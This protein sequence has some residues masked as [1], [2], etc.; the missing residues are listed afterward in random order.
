MA[1]LVNSMKRV[2]KR[3]EA[4]T[5]YQSCD[6]AKWFNSENFNADIINYFTL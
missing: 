2:N 6:Y 5:I 4:V 3:T 1:K